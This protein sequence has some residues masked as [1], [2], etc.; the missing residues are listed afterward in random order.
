MGMW[1]SRRVGRHVATSAGTL[2]ARNILGASIRERIDTESQGPGPS[3]NQ[4]N[5][6][7]L[8]SFQEEA[9]TA[10]AQA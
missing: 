4:D 2:S 3:T 5:P 6:S 7:G 8:F 10:G 1:V 9:G